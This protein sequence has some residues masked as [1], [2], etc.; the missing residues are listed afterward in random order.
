[1]KHPEFVACQFHFVPVW[2]T[3][4]CQSHIRSRQ[5]KSTSHKSGE[6]KQKC[7]ERQPLIYESWSGGCVTALVSSQM[8]HAFYENPSCSLLVFQAD[9]SLHGKHKLGQNW[10]C[11]VVI[12]FQT[13]WQTQ[14]TAPCV[15]TRADQE[16]QRAV[17]WNKPDLWCS[18]ELVYLQSPSI[19]SG[20][21]QLSGKQL[22]VSS[23]STHS[24]VCPSPFLSKF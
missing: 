10:G 11:D 6:I 21:Q 13:T 9:H 2:W 8:K 19:N 12:L 7:A 3:I 4:V 24:T 5:V 14:T 18:A 20:Q 15:T 17:P 22:S 23:N 16:A 1:M